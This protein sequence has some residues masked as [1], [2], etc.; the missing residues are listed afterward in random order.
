M[1]ELECYCWRLMQVWQELPNFNHSFN[2]LIHCGFWLLYLSLQGRGVHALDPQHPV[3]AFSGFSIP[4]LSPFSSVTSSSPW[5]QCDQYLN[6]LKFLHLYN[7]NKTLHGVFSTLLWCFL[8]LHSQT[9][10]RV[11]S[12]PSSNSSPSSLSSTHS[13]GFSS[14]HSL[15]W[16]AYQMKVT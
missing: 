16:K 2:L 14:A 6:I 10:Q 5:A 13:T 1:V 15:Q 3:T 9:S 8:P 12:V 4:Q 7:K 11:V